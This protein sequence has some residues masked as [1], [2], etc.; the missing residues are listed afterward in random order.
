MEVAPGGSKQAGGSRWL[1]VARTRLMHCPTCN[2]YRPTLFGTSIR[3]SLATNLMFYRRGHRDARSGGLRSRRGCGV[4]NGGKRHQFLG[5]VH[6][7]R[8]GGNFL[9]FQLLPS[10]SGS[11]R[12]TAANLNPTTLYTVLIVRYPQRWQPRPTYPLLCLIEPVQ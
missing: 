12:S 4:W 10:H 6:L 2:T 7:R 3:L 11:V 8:R 5:R 9:L 1:Q